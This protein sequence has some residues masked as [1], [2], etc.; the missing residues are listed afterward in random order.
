MTFPPPDDL[1]RSPT[2]RVPAWVREE[3]AGRAATPT[4]WR[5]PVATGYPAT[6]WSPAPYVPP[7]KRRR[8]R[9]MVVSVVGLL[10]LLGLGMQEML[11]WQT[12]TDLTNSAWRA[13]GPGFMDLGAD[14][15]ALLTPS[16]GYGEAKTR[17]LPRVTVA[18]PDDAYLVQ[19]LPDPF[20]DGEN[21]FTWSPC[22]PIEYTVNLDGAPDDFTER[23]EAAVTEIS[24]ATGLA[25]VNDGPTTEVPTVERPRYQPDRYGDRWAPVLI[26]FA[27]DTEIPRLAGTVVGLGGADSAF[28]PASKTYRAVSGIVYLDIELT[29][30]RRL[31]GEP[32]YVSVLRHELGHL[33]GLDHIDDDSQL[34][35]PSGPVTEFQSGDLTGLAEVGAGECAPGL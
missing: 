19:T 20:G 32:L 25:F 27:D 28:D 30:E 33:V 2:G 26:A 17:L 29:E 16:P 18:E 4:E 22:R 13:D 15:D 12:R 3:A 34:M 8:T 24:A 10:V 5:A 35:A 11:P 7:R 23:V 21:P 31:W 1:P 6:P 9:A 14:D